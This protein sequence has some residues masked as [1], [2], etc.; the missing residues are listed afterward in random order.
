VRV[1]FEEAP[2]RPDL[3]PIESSRRFV[4]RQNV[5]LVDSVGQEYQCC[6]SFERTPQRPDLS[7]LESRWRRIPRDLF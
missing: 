5:W 3:S 7:P 4:R 2:Q 6:I 1:L